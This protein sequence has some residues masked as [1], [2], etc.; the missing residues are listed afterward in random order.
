MPAQQSVEALQPAQRLVEAIIPAQ[1]SVEVPTHCL[2]E[3]FF[4]FNSWTHF[5]I[6][7]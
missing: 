3:V 6:Q 2:V 4:P 7:L 5:W 1:Q